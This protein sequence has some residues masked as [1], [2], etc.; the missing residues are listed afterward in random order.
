MINIITN[1]L[2]NAHYFIDD[3]TYHY[4]K[5]LTKAEKERD[6]DKKKFY[7]ILDRNLIKRSS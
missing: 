6:I 5:L 1:S 3:N 7:I 2:I 4:I